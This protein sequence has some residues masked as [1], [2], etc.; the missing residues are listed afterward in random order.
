VLGA[1][2]T[3]NNATVRSYNYSYDLMGNRLTAQTF[4]GATTSNTTSLYNLANQLVSSQ[5]D[6]GPS[7]SYSYDLNGN[8]TSDGL[9]SYAY[10]A[11]N[12]LKSYTDGT[13]SAVTNYLYDGRG[14]RLSQTTGSH[15]TTYLYDLTGDPAQLLGQTADGVETRYLVGLGG[16]IGQQQNNTWGYFGYDGLGSVRQLTD[17]S[18]ALRYS[19]NYDP[20]GV[21]FYQAGD[22]STILGFAGEPTDPNGLQFLSTRYY[23]PAAGEFISHDPFAGNLQDILSQNG[24]TYADANPVNNFDPSGMYCQGTTLDNL[25]IFTCGIQNLGELAT[26]AWNVATNTATLPLQHPANTASII[27]NTYIYSSENYAKASSDALSAVGTWGTEGHGFALLATMGLDPFG[28]FV[29][30]GAE[31]TVQGASLVQK[32]L[33]IANAVSTAE[34]LG[35]CVLANRAT[36]GQPQSD[37]KSSGTTTV[38]GRMPDLEKYGKERWIPGTPRPEYDTWWKSGRLPEDPKDIKQAVKW[39]ENV[40][41]LQQR[42]DLGDTF[43]IATNPAKL[44]DEKDYVWGEPN[45]NYTRRELEWLRQPPRNIEPIP[46]Y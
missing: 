23:N 32:V 19:A 37:K 18:G 12:R 41:W 38:I 34:Q 1:T 6:S 30:E 15:T 7:R 4:D 29:G 27:A 22:M 33:N 24:Y 10:D 8:M 46:M 26:N 39:S 3:A 25:Q 9:N 28:G 20:Y 36:K 40:A 5:T 16:I 45:G 31:D 35:Q 21:P 13:N 42:I 14:H 44:P 11:V 43:G 2:Y 17:A